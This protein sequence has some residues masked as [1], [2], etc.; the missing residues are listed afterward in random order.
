MNTVLNDRILW[1]SGISETSTAN[2]PSLC[3]KH[4]MLPADFLITE[5]SED[6]SL[7]NEVYP[8]H[9]IKTSPVETAF[10]TEFLLTESFDLFDLVVERFFANN[11][12]GLLASDITIR[13]DRIEQ[14]FDLIKQYELE[15]YIKSVYI[16]AQQLRERNIVWAGRGSSCACYTLYIL[17]I[18][19]IDSVQ[20]NIPYTEFFR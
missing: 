12:D 11:V 7:F 5:A 17:G 13:Y 9:K 6:V 15:D 16:I 2:I 14:E 19:N 10:H 20:F 1:H 8:L 3:V 18:H 4:K